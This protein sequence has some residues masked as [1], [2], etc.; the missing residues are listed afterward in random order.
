ME[1]ICASPCVT[2]LLCFSM[3]AKH[4]S[5]AAPLDAKAH[6]TRH[7]LG[8]RGNALSFP[9]PWEDMLKTLQEHE[10]RA[11]AAE[12]ERPSALPRAGKHLG[13]VVR[14]LLK[15][16]KTGQTTDAEI[17]TLIHQAN[18]RR[19]VVV[20]LILDMKKLGHPAYQQIEEA[21]VRATAAQLPED[22]VPTEVLKVIHT[23]GVEGENDDDKLQPQK[24][25]TPTDGR[26]EDAGHA[27]EVFAQQRPR[28]IAAEGC[29]EDHE[30]PNAV[31]VAA[32]NDLETQLRPQGAEK[33]METL[34][35][36]TGNQLI[37]QFRPLYF[38]TAFCFCFKHAT[39]CPDAQKRSDERNGAAARQDREKNRRARNP[40]A[41][42]VEVHAWA[43]AMQRRA[44]T[45]FR[46]DWTFGFTLWNYLFRTMVNLQQNSFMYTVPNEDGSGHRSLSNLEIMEGLQEIQTRVG[47]SGLLAGVQK[48]PE[49]FGAGALRGVTHRIG[50]V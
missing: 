3:E 10:E 41:P 50:L 16:N 2:T 46:R 43:S 24:A 36:C 27:G 5:E 37:D 44:E 22:A 42:P 26:I 17:K 48:F 1:M 21:A 28:A 19:E 13:E 6:A 7:R 45:Q 11:D 29:S 49:N 30:D 23:L 8:A 40:K 18:V 34:E 4:R 33:K 14:V 25:A 47:Q 39:A 31:A 15:T 35:V 12:A 38:A 20:Q 9:L 32:L